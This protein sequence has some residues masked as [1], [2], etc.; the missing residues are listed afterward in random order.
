M[1]R[2]RKEILSPLLRPLSK[3]CKKLLCCWY[4]VLW[5]FFLLLQFFFCMFLF[6]SVWFVYVSLLLNGI[7][8]LLMKI[9][10]KNKMRV[11]LAW[12]RWV[13]LW[14]LWAICFHMIL[15]DFFSLRQFTFV[16]HRKPQKFT[17]SWFLFLMAHAHL[18][19]FFFCFIQSFDLLSMT[20]VAGQ[21]KQFLYVHYNRHRLKDSKR[22]TE[23][24]R[25]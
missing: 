12:N 25:E 10:G 21:T 3:F 4:L 15:L 14:L 2:W 9:S 22:E 19:A 16:R 13:C 5:Y 11:S 7:R 1:N 6:F 18:F 20:D 8:T 24:T 17:V 23:T